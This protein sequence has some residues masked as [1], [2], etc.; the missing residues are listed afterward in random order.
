MASGGIE[1]SPICC[2]RNKLFELVIITDLTIRSLGEARRT[3][4]AIILA[5]IT[6]SCSPTGQNRLDAIRA[7]GQLAVVTYRSP[8]T[9]YDNPE[10]PA[11]FE[12]DLVRAFADHLG[13]NLKL[14][15]VDGLTAVLPRLLTGEVDMAAAGLA[16]T[17]QRRQLVDFGIP[18]QHIR[19]QLVYR[20]GTLRPT[21]IA[22]LVGRQIE[23]R[24]A[25]SYADRL[26]ELK[27]EYPELSWIEVNDKETDELLQLVWEG[28]V[29]ITIADSH[30]V[31]INRQFFPELQVA[32]DF[33]K[34][35]PLA[36]AFPK[37]ED[38]SLM[39]AAKTFLDDQRENGFLEQLI[40][41][42]YGPA[43]RSNF[44]NLT[45]YHLRIRNRLP[46][47]QSLFENAGRKYGIDWR[48][49]AAVGY[50]ES[51]WD[52]AAVS[53]TGV[54]GIMMLT[55]ETA[56]QLGLTDRLDPAQSI[57][58][59]ARYLRHL[60]DRL[61]PTI[62]EPDRIW[63]ALA[64]YNFGLN[65]LRDARELTRANRGNPNAWNDVKEML[66]KLRVR[67]WYQ[68]GQPRG[69]EPIVFVN[70]VRTYYDILLKIDEEAKALER[71]DALRLQAP[72]I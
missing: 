35:E 14:V 37:S 49:L 16:A 42:Y 31:A 38:D 67:S 34:P 41:R 61:A 8:T 71:P 32:F 40:E 6:G 65:R 3:L 26:K 19:Q 72:A 2:S 30:I 11:G 57:G 70:R 1:N 62:Q 23:V 36:W 21:G 33:Q 10:G 64:A 9:Y 52:P 39:R 15:V 53:P 25:T 4:G 69:L 45:V 46:A 55:E 7:D 56:N 12:Y 22:D 66:P 60:I 17:Q 63:M 20:L 5:I 68:K 13:V 24:A 18:Y 47:Y 59:G 28:L 43:K 50:Q 27:Q 29:E 51:F 48:L 44:I 58:G 54:R